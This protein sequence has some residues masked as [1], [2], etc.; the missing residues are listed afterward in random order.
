MSQIYSVC[1]AY[2]IGEH[3]DWNWSQHTAG[4]TR[5]EATKLAIEKRGSEDGYVAEL[6]PSSVVG[7]P[8]MADPPPSIVSNSIE[9]V[10]L[11]DIAQ[12]RKIDE[13]DE[14][15]LY[16]AWHI[17]DWWAPN[18]DGTCVRVVF[19]SLRATIDIPV[20][21][22]GYENE[23][24]F[25]GVF[26]DV[27]ISFYPRDYDIPPEEAREHFFCEYVD[28]SQFISDSVL[29]QMRKELNKCPPTTN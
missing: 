19:D 14:K 21:F 1:W 28:F 8:G 4:W 16:G 5:Y 12:P 29:N 6:Y 9:K 11:I 15:S 25:V 3:G 26:D 17:S 18:H 13:D 22:S 23:E 24:V 7:L 20:W 2:R 10:K 27:S